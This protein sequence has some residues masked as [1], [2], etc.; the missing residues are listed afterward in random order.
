MNQIVNRTFRLAGTFT[1]ESS[2]WIKLSVMAAH[3]DS[4]ILYFALNHRWEKTDRS[5]GNSRNVLINRWSNEHVYEITDN[6]QMQVSGIWRCTD[7]SFFFFFFF[8]QWFGS[9][10]LE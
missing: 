1:K 10:S 3:R 6:K 7:Y 4:R 9:K 8:T 2:V 5:V